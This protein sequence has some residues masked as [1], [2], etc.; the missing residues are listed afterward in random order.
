MPTFGE[1]EILGEPLARREDHGDVTTVWQARK[2]GGEPRLYAIK[3]Y[4]PGARPRAEGQPQEALERDRALEFLE[5]IKQI[6]KAQSEGGRGLAPIYALGR[7]DSEAW[8]ATDFYPRKNLRAFIELQGKVEGGALR[9]IVHSIAS[10]CLALKRSRGY[11][12][13][14]LK[15]ANVFLVGS[16]RRALR[17]TPFHLTDAYPASPLQLGRLE[18]GDRQ[19]ARELL[20]QVTEAQDLR[21]LGEIILQLV[22]GRLFSRADDYNYPVE[23]SPAWG[24]LGKSSERWRDLCNRLL[25]PNLSLEM[26][27]LEALERE[28]KPS[29]VEG[30]MPLI[31]GVS[32]AVIV[33]GGGGYWAMSSLEKSRALQ[34]EKD[35][36]TALEGAKSGLAATNLASA[37]T[38]ID[39]ALKLRPT[40]SEVARLKS[41]IDELDAQT[42]SAATNAAGAAYR[43]GDYTNAMVAAEGALVI[44]Q[45]DAGVKRLK[46]DAEARWREAIAL[47]GRGEEYR[48]ATN[49]ARVAFR[50][51]N[52]TNAMSQADK[53]LG[54][55]PNDASIKQLKAEAQTRW[56]AMVTAVSR[57]KEYRSATNAA[58]LA[59]RRGDYTNAM[60]EAGKALVIN[61]EN[62]AMKQV[63][64]DAQARWI[65][66]L[67]AAN[68]EQEYVSATNTA[69]RAFRTGNYTNAMSEA[70]KALGIH[71]D[72]AGIKQLR[73]DS[74][75]RW[76][77]T[78]TSEG[79]QQEY[80][81]ATNAAWTA[82]QQGNYTNAM[83]AAD[84]A[85]FIHPDDAIT[86]KLK[87]DAQTRWNDMIAAE[88]R[89]REYG[90]ATN[91]AWQAFE[92]GR[93]A[94]T[95]T[96]LDKAMA[97]HTNEA[98]LKRLKAD[99]QARLREQIA[100]QK[101]KA[102]DDL[103][104]GAK[105]L[106]EATNFTA[107]GVEF[108]K[109]LGLAAELNNLERKKT[110]DEG[111]NLT[112]ELTKAEAANKIGSTGEEINH[113]TEALKFN[114]APK[115]VTAWLEKAKAMK[116]GVGVAGHPSKT[117]L[118]DVDFV[119]IDG[120]GSNRSGAY[121]AESELSG[122]EY[123]NLHVQFGIPS[124]NKVIDDEKLPARFDTFLE[125]M[126]FLNKVN[127]SP[128]LVGKF[129][130]PSIN[131]YKALADIEFDESWV[132]SEEGVRRLQQDGEN[133]A[134]GNAQGK[135]APTSEGP[136]RKGL[137]NVVGNV[138]E[139]CGDGN[140]FGVS[141]LAEITGI[142]SRTAK[143]T[144]RL[145]NERVGLRLVYE[146][147]ANSPSAR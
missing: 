113:L 49:A 93:Y 4:A 14:N 74:Q 36:R 118:F 94:E 24:R 103:L 32:V 41:Q 40:V 97:I 90:S 15:P 139:W 23:R 108:R 72:D 47:A 35:F 33:L 34:K 110:A 87:A 67:A 16:K 98:A 38:Q 70:D 9:H 125:A 111:A 104:A 27:N 59:Y 21:A 39:K 138:A 83:A 88:S 52:Y 11:S 56:D 80:R 25:N 26:V 89:D 57:E 58:T 12:H 75:A 73:S 29:A 7:T 60:A 131:E 109:A 63:M 136:I 114:G 105:R 17:Q 106:L 62:A 127:S 13:G 69:W 137:R 146:Q 64:S 28:F 10:G 78:I 20:G 119:W 81:L 65:Q 95:L 5:G 76:N 71:R 121:V 102:L 2:A 96:Q 130:L 42:F 37:R 116:G 66:G 92:Q 101:Q 79:R 18:A 6:K 115:W 143:K 141:Y 86:K 82:F 145:P 147:S 31:V 134:K 128:S 91:A 48:S 129:R 85:L 140:T 142:N 8:Y 123:L 19:E 135:P 55:N 122:K 44:R 100:T 84:K 117:N 132:P 107:S 124:E 43:R 30:K 126:N 112:D 50:Q 3:C 22:E 120:L 144:K 77:E 54:I 51:A 61:P 133:V 46:A 53:A 99:T 45:D 1:F 68:R